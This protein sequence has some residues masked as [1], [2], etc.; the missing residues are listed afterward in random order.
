MNEHLISLLLLISGVAGYLLGK[1]ILAPHI[2]SGYERLKKKRK[3]KELPN[4]FVLIALLSGNVLMQVNIFLLL[5]GLYEDY[6]LSLL[7][8]S[9]S[10]L[11]LYVFLLIAFVKAFNMYNP[12]KEI[13][14]SII[15][16]ETLDKAMDSYKKGKED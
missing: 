8:I 5:L 10:I 11:F 6:Q 14:N 12:N 13:I 9:F 4:P 3:R 2:K 15:K 7:F 1:H 16:S